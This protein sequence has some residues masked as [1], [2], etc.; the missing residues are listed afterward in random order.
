[1]LRLALCSLRN[2]WT[3]ATL[4]VATIAVS[5]ALL[6]GVQM[7]R[8]AGKESFETALSGTDL[9]VG[10]RTGDVNLLLLA[11]FRIGDATAN[12]SWN[13]YRKIASHPDVAWTV[14]ISLGDMHRGFRVLGTTSEYFVHYRYND[15]RTIR[16]TAGGPFDGPGDAV[17][18]A[19][20]AQALHYRSGDTI[21]ISHGTGAASFVQHDDHPLRIAGVLARTGT[22][23]D[24]AVHVSLEAI[25]TIHAEGASQQPAPDSITA[26]LVGMRSKAMTL[27][28]QRAINTYRA[29][30]LTAII[31]GVTLGTLWKLVGTADRALTIISGFVVVAG[32][33]GMMASILAGLNERRRE[34]A[35]LRAI[36]ARPHHVFG[37][38]VAEAGL[39]VS[40]GVL[41]GAVL[42]LGVL[43]AA[44]PI[45]AA[46]FGIEIALRAPGITELWMLAAIV[47][48][49]LTTGLV[50]AARAYFN[51]LGDGLQLKT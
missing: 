18:G 5:V 24:R 43:A 34:M 11:V 25:A 8:K 36:G 40:A 28:M 2:R 4:V 45:I 21:T 13:S 12:V 37:L 16:F 39:L 47:M 3:T 22:P 9:L 49:G 29:E 27:T 20:V 6:L 42:G 31:P 26:F 33:L 32:L 50:P 44:K 35:I 1:M 48:A 10:A 30:P 17:I 7:I 15:G 14:P 51:S 38:L 19:D 41:F 46:R 23:V